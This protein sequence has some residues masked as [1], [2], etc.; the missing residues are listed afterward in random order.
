MARPQEG[1]R[2]ASWG[3]VVLLPV[4]GLWSRAPDPDDRGGSHAR[5]AGVYGQPVWCGEL[6]EPDIRS[7]QGR[8]GDPPQEFAQ[9]EKAR[10][11]R[12]WSGRL[13]GGRIIR[14]VLRGPS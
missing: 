3:A 6:R 14:R 1:Y 7:V 11:I 4:R 13:S 2:A 9:G 5:I 12:G 10:L 8:R